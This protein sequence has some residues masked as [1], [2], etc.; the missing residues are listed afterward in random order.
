MNDKWMTKGLLVMLSLIFVV[1]A[2]ASCGAKK[3]D[4]EAL[5]QDVGTVQAQVKNNSQKIEANSGQ[6]ESNSGQLEAT[7]QKMETLETK[8]IVA[9]LRAL[10]EQIKLTADAAATQTALA[11]A[12]AALGTVDAANK[13]AAEQALADAKAALEA[14]AVA[15]KTTAAE[16]LATAKAALEAADTANSQ[17]AADALANAKATLEAALAENAATDAT[18]KTALENAMAE[19]AGIVAQNKSDAEQALIDAKALLETADTAIAEAA[20]TALAEVKATLEA[21]DETNAQAAADALATAKADLEAKL[22]ENATA[23]AATKEALEAAI[24]DLTSVVAQNKADTEAALINLKAELETADTAVAEAVAAALAEVKATLEAADEANAQAAAVALANAQTELQTALAENAATDAANNAALEAAIAELTAVV[25]QN[26]ADAEAALINLKAELETADTAVANAAAQALAGVKAILE[27]A[28]EANIQAAAEAL[29]NAKA[30]LEAKLSENVTADAATKEAL[31]TAIAE[32]TAVVSQNKAA[33]EQA[34]VDLKAELVVADTAVANAAAEALA[35][36]KAELEGTIA[37]NKEAIEGA[38]ETAVNTLEVAYQA[39]DQAITDSLNTLQTQHNTLSG[40]VEA[41]ETLIGDIG[42]TTVAAEIKDIKDQ[43]ALLG[44]DIAT[45]MKDFIDGYDLASEILAGE[46]VLEDFANE[47]DYNTYSVLTLVNFDARIKTFTDRKEWY[48]NIGG[49]AAEQYNAFD[50]KTKNLRFFLGRATSKETVKLYFDKLEAA[51]E[52]LM[53]LDELFAVVVDDIIDNKKVTDLATSYEIATKIK[54]AITDPPLVI[55]AEYLEKYD[56]IVDA[57]ENLAAAKA[58][59]KNDVE[60]Y[61]SLIAAPIVF[62][63][64]DTQID[65]AREKFGAFDTYYFQRAEVVELVKLYDETKYTAILL[66]DNYSALTAAEARMSE[67]EMAD[68]AKPVIIEEVANFA[69]ERPLWSDYEAIK[70]LDEAIATWAAGNENWAALETANVEAIL[71]AGNDSLVDQ[72]LAYA[73][74]MKGYYNQYNA[75]DSLKNLIVDINDDTL[76]LYSR[77]TE[78]KTAESKL[79]NLENAIRGY[80]DYVDALDENFATMIG[81]DNINTF[82]SDAVTGQMERLHTAKNTLNGYKLAIEG[83]ITIKYEKD[84]VEIYD[85]AF[86]DTIKTN[87][88]V[89]ASIPAIQEGDANYELI[90]KPA[91]DAYNRWIDAYKAKTLVIAEIADAA[92]KA[93]TVGYTLAEGNEIVRINKLILQLPDNGV[94]N[95]NVMIYLDDRAEPFN[96]KN[97]IDK[98]NGFAA[99]FKAKAEKAQ[100]DA[101]A[102]N[103]LVTNAFKNLSTDNLNNYT[104][105]KAAYGA[106][107]AWADEHLGGVYTWDAVNAIQAIYKVDAPT[108]TYEFV[109][110]ANF[111]VLDDMNTK[112]EAR[113]ALS[114]TEWMA[115]SELFGQLADRWVD[116]LPKTETQWNIH[117]KADFEA[118]DAAYAKFLTKFYTDANSGAGTVN[119]GGGY[120]G[121][122]AAYGLFDAE[123]TEFNTLMGTVNTRFSEISNAINTLMTGG[124]DAIDASHVSTIAAIRANMASFLTDYDCDVLTCEGG[125]AITAD[126]RIFLARAQAKAAYTEKYNEAVV[127]AAGDATK[128]GKLEIVLSNANQLIG[129]AT[130]DGTNGSIQY[131][132]DFA[133]SQFETALNPA[134]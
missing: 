73:T 117:S 11:E 75:E 56:L 34:L 80:V 13:A 38:L 3:D 19:L 84:D 49:I 108:E 115:V 18:N 61:I 107:T 55:P 8:A 51:I 48:T 59:V 121:E 12:K 25:A 91:M 47:T 63:T 5:K 68:A 17:A 10:T 96:L 52:E 32:L 110:L 2:F 124:L 133:T 65:T 86:I 87:I 125:Y 27:A 74:A 33:V 112:A 88:S 118:A 35:T 123:Y 7:D 36:A 104:E 127:T 109:L 111:E 102:V 54:D 81:E 50:E 106:F 119:D 92:D 37:A 77:Y 42:D 46:A 60:D 29:A 67:L 71:G 24:A 9:E 72:A 76:Q 23:D 132:Y 31:E 128:L 43:L 82:R 85:Y 79:N 66:V 45:T 90:V 14:S 6:I 21:T 89:A 70:S 39:A 41:M 93:M 20:A 105:I 78:F 83:K 28:D 114:A 44:S 62:G 69:A 15:D 95:T 30:D 16:A 97:V 40:K 58:A 129:T 122:I 22:S 98:W 103:A 116:G 94:G 4:F 113:K 1:T 64:S 53:T 57:Q 131:V 134:A 26:K 99:E 100:S 101:V 126:Q 130:L 120:N